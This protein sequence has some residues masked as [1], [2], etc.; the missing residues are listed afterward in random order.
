MRPKAPAPGFDR[1]YLDRLRAPGPKATR[2]VDKRSLNFH[3]LGFIA[4]ILAGA[5]V[6]HCR[7]HPIDTPRLVSAIYAA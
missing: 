3:Y 4:T 6:V 7:R 2:I 1:A 5:R